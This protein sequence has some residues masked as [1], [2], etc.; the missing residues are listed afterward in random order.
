MTLKFVKSLK[1]LRDQKTQA[2]YLNEKTGKCTINYRELTKPHRYYR[3]GA[4][5]M[6]LIM[7]VCSTPLKVGKIF[8]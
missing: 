4:K 8:S 2:G 7:R 1:S 5:K 3:I 6:E